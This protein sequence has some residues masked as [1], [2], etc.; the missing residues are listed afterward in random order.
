MFVSQR[1]KGM[2]GVQKKCKNFKIFNACADLCKSCVDTFE[3]CLDLYKSCVDSL[4]KNLLC[5][6]LK[7]LHTRHIK[8][9]LHASKLNYTCRL[10]THLCRLIEA[11]FFFYVST[12]NALCVDSCI[13]EAITFKNYPHVS[14][15]SM[16]VSIHRPVFHIKTYFNA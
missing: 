16:Y 4:E 6:D 9:K 1:Q 12:R 13:I 2:H 3:A 11:F 7:P 14:T 8:H 15:H 5:V 10:I